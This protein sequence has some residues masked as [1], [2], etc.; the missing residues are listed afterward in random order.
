M[1]MAQS[2]DQDQV[3][4]KLV[5]GDLDEKILQILNQLCVGKCGV[6]LLRYLD[7]HANSL[8]TLEDIAYSLRESCSDVE[9]G[10]NTLQEL[11]LACELR[12]AGIS[13]FGATPDQ[14]GRVRIRELRAWQERWRV[15]IKRIERLVDGKPEITD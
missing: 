14:N 1:V 6:A 7:V 9:C 2:F 15:R 3:I 4:Q 5:L 8:H 12:I 10:L 13:F 11:G